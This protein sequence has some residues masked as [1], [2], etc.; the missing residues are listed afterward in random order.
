[1]EHWEQA[2]FKAEEDGWKALGE[3]GCLAMMV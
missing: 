2:I 1:M 3:N